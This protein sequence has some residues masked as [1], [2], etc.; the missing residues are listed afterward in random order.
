M[1]A[2]IFGVELPAAMIAI[3]ERRIKI[4]ISGVELNPVS[5][6][7]IARAI[8]WVTSPVELVPWR[9]ARIVLVVVSD[10]FGVD[11]IAPIAAK[12]S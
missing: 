3:K 10:K 6:A 9:F 11:E 5:E 7:N 1:V 8:V 4:E 2:V 12:N